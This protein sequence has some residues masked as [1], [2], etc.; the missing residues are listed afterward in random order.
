MPLSST[1]STALK[2]TILTALTALLLP[3]VISAQEMDDPVPLPADFS[4]HRIYVH[5]VT[6][7][8]D[9]LRLYTD[10]GGG[11]LMVKPT[12]EKLDLSILDT[13]TVRGRPV[14]IAEWPDLS[15]EASV[16]PPPE[17]RVYVFPAGGQAKLLNV[18]DGMLGRSWFDGH[19]WTFDYG[20]EQFLL[21]PS[22]DDASF[23]ASHT[24]PLGFKTDSTGQRTEHFPS[25]EATIDGETYA[26]LFDTGA[27]MVL[28]DSVHTARGGPQV[29]G[30]SF[31]TAS[32]FD[33]WR[34][35]HPD[36][37]VLENTARSA[38]VIDVPE[39]TIADHTVGPVRFVRRPDRNF[40]QG[41]SSMMDRRVEGALGGSLFQYFVITVDYPS[42]RAHFQQT[43]R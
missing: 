4:A 25:I 20:Q 10:T 24:V 27:S 22:D 35:A 30:T 39:V 5:P 32:L 8:G 31:V 36:W 42:A 6:A 21:H 29:R 41:M 13:T 37:P 3:G 26:F 34:N 28:T 23:D 15:P 2:S 9:T 11:N 18:G 33:Q 1:F 14:P 17:H 40:H 16:P 12:V 19:V 43:S 38:P 7:S